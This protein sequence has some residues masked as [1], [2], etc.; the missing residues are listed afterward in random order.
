MRRAALAALALSIGLA[1]LSSTVEPVVASAQAAPTMNVVLIVLDDWRWD[2]AGVPTALN[3]AFPAS[4]LPIIREELVGQG[5][6]GSNAFVVNSL[7]CPSRASI[8]TGNYSH[9]TGVWNNQSVLGR[10][11]FA[12]FRPK[13]GSTLATWFDG[14]GYRTALVGKY[15]NGYNALTYRPRGWDRWVAFEGRSTGYFNYRLTIDGTVRSYGSSPADY[16]TD[17]LGAYAVDVI[18]TTPADTPLFL[19]FTPYAPHAPFTPAPR[20]LGMFAGYQPKMPPNLAEADVSDKPAWVR[21]LA[22]KGGSWAATKRKQMEMLMAVDDAIGSIVTAL[23][24]SGRLDNTAIVL[25]SD[26]GLSGGSHRWTSKKS[27]WDE[28]IRVPLIIRA[29]SVPPATT[30]R[31]LMLN[32]DIA[33]TLSELTGVPIPMTDGVSLLSSLQGDPTPLRTVFGIEHL[34]DTA[35]PPSYC[36]VRT[37]THKYV[38]YSTGEEELYDLVNDPWEL[39]S[40]HASP[41][42]ASLKADLLAETQAICDPPPP[43]YSF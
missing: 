34:V 31:Q 35:S 38:R 10:G 13:E 29:P 39:S 21:A 27:A 3:E 18:D 7:C 33:D 43:G 12:S 41:A 14:A 9:T 6:F 19:Y 23:Q 37:L 20:H 4:Y 25:T 36:G 26:N 32:I 24:Q 30:N 40:V 42:Y 28:A 1:V 2:E 11:G 16:S 22:R 8:L 17:V 5:F 15:V